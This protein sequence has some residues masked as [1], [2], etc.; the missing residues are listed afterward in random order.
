MSIK[1]QSSVPWTLPLAGRASPLHI[2]A[3]VEESYDRA[4]VVLSCPVVFVVSDLTSA[5]CNRSEP[6]RTLYVCL[7]VCMYIC[8]MS[9]RRLPESPELSDISLAR[10]C[11]LRMRR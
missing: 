9:V 1:S 6:T 3:A 11:R 4:C 2:H 8:L 5:G 10:R 7:F